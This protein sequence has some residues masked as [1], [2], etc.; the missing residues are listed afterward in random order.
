MLKIKTAHIAFLLLFLVIIAVNIAALNSAVRQPFTLDETE[1]ARMGRKINIIGP[2]T[3][4]LPPEEGGETISHALLYTYSHAL[5]QRIFGKG[6]LALRLYG[7]FHYLLSLFLVLAIISEV[8]PGGDKYLRRWA[9]YIAAVLYLL[10][11]LLLQHCLV[12]N[13]DNNILTTAILVFIYFFIRFEVKTEGGEDRKYVLSRFPLA[14]LLALCFWAKELTPIFVSAGIVLYRITA[15]D[16]K[17]AI[18]DFFLV[19]ILGLVL[20]WL[21]WWLYCFFTATDVLAFVKFTII[22]KSKYAFRLG[23]IKSILD[24]FFVVFRWPLYWVSA[25]FFT[26]L[27]L[28]LFQRIKSFFKQKKAVITDCIFLVAACVWFPYLFFK[29]NPDMMKYQYPAYPLF[30]IFISY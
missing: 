12:I 14:F 10:N 20:F 3:F 16:V 21:T 2:K 22:N 7:V 15:G 6:D 23:F 11:P 24:G 25:P 17:K 30:I 28:L 19:A 29:P 1:E 18:M 4:T 8:T 27:I 5:V 13:A 9:K 26:I